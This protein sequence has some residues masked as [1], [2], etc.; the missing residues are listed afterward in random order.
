LVA[1]RDIGAMVP[2]A[3]AIGFI[4]ILAIERGSY[5]QGVRLLGSG[6]AGPTK[7][8]WLLPD[9]R[10]TYDE[11][12]AAARAALGELDFA[13]AWAEGGGMTLEHAIACAVTSVSRAL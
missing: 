11:I 6:D 7:G 12:L 8:W 3:A 4:G 1:F 10:R 13:A 2:L 9:E 5:W